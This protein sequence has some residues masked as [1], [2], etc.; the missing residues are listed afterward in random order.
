M[1]LNQVYINGA[2]AI[3]IQPDLS[4][5][6]LTNPLSFRQNYVRCADPNFRD[7]FDPMA[8]RRMSKIIKRAII[9]ADIALK[10][11][12]IELP[13]AVISGTGLGCVEETEKFLDAMIQN[14]EKFLQ[15]TYFI[16]S[17]HNTIS[18]Q[19]AIKLGCRGYNNTYIHRG[20]S[21]ENGLIDAL[22]QLNKND[23]QTALVTGNDEMTPNYHILLGRLGYWKTEIEDT[24]HI[25]KSSTGPGSFAGEGSVSIVLGSA[26]NQHTYA[27]LLAMDLS[28]KPGGLSVE[29]IREFLRDN[30]LSA[31]DIDVFLTGMNGDTPNDEVYKAFETVFGEN[32]MACFRHLVGTYHTSSAFGLHTAATCIK[33][34]E[35]PAPLMLSGNRSNKVKYILLYNHFLNKDHSLILLSAC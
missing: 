22:L 3:S 7:Y 31:E 5:N 28:Y 19:I 33:H 32:K 4:I 13:D 2:G 12:Q 11:A 20:V 34:Q 18:S 16:Q 23:I 6:G 10:D 30:N 29:Y 26:R 9:T 35:V 1:K 8:A 25:V 17:T 27:R 24:L 15:P 21:F 14:E